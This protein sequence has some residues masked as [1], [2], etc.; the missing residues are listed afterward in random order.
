[1]CGVCG[2]LMC[3]AVSVR[4]HNFSDSPLFLL[5]ALCCFTPL[6]YSS[7]LFCPLLL[8]C[9]QLPI[10]FSLVLS[11]DS[12][13]RYCSFF[14]ASHIASICNV[15][16]S[17]FPT[18]SC[19]LFLSLPLCHSFLSSLTHYL[20]SFLYLSLFHRISYSIQPLH[21]TER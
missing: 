16:P 14:H 13:F 4:M 9:T 2:V 10:F 11:Y 7:P 17:L 20:F 18:L 1:V 8:L 6:L 5:E 19:H 21:C 15:S 3:G 12:P